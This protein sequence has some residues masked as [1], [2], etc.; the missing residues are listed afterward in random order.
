[1]TSAIDIGIPQLLIALLFVI[2][3]GVASLRLRL[4]LER[5][6]LW[7]TVRTVAQL[8]LMGFVLIYV[9]QLRQWYLIVGLFV[10]MI[11]FAAW[12]IHGRVRSTSVSSLLTVSSL[13]LSAFSSFFSAGFPFLPIASRIILAKSSFSYRS[14]NWLPPLAAIL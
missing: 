14:A 5:D 1:M 3:A 7:G 4:G 12:I 13:G 6:L 2:S 8:V 9:F 10:V 11:L